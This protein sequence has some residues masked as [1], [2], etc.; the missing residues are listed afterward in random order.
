MRFH[1]FW[2]AAA[3]FC[4]WTDAF[5]ETSDWRINAPAPEPSEEQRKQLGQLVCGNGGFELL[6]GKIRCKLCPKYT[7]NADS[8]EGLT[9]V[10]ALRGRFTSKG[11]E[12]EWILD[13]EGCEAHYSSFG[14][15]IL[16]SHIAP[17]T[18]PSMPSVGL[19]SSLAAKPA[20]GALALTFYKPGFR[21]SDC[22]PWVGKDER[23]LLVC[24]EA[25]LAQGEV[26]GHLSSMEISR[27]GISRWRLLRWYDN[28]AGDALQVI[29]VVPTGMRRMELDDG[30]SGLQVKLKMFETSRELLEK[31]LKPAA[32]QVSLLFQQKGQRFFATKKTQGQLKVISALTRKVLE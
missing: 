9:V 27:R 12:N 16:L 13:T 29:S 32:K 25:D 21:V 15:V 19:G 5:A 4:A 1:S 6:E 23:I 11:L 2:L 3:F 18:F 14:G 30:Q 8:A 17:K 28:T 20:G 7:G 22:M 24:N 31:G 10:S 26:I